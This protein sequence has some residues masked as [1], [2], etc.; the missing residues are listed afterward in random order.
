MRNVFR[1]K[2]PYLG[3]YVNSYIVE[4]GNKTLLIDSGLAS[5]RD[6]LISYANHNT[7]LLSTHGHWD[8]VGNHR[9]LQAQG[10]WVYAHAGDGYY[11]SN[12]DWQW[13]IQFE[14]FASDFDLPPARRITYMAEFDE[15]LRPDV[16]LQNGDHLTIGDSFVEVIATLGHS[17]GSVCFLMPE[18]GLLFHGRYIDGRRV[19]R[20]LSAM[21][22]S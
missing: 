12:L 14:Q 15:P 3:V 7:A 17:D 18:D 19:F 22:R 8:H 9:F 1:C 2:Y 5:G 10:V 11:Y 6:K 4:A 16:Y 13:E 20:W 21:H